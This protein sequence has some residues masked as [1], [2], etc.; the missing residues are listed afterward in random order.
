MLS[1]NGLL[2]KDLQ[3]HISKTNKYLPNNSQIN[4]S[5]HNSPCTF[6]IMGLPHFFYGFVTNLHKVYTANGADQSKVKFSKQKPVFSVCFLLI[7]MPFYSQYLKDATDK[8][9]YENLNGKKL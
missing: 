7:G 9:I 2:L 8:V 3:S 1:V 5:L 4:V 6:I